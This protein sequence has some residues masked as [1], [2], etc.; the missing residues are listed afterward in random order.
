MGNPFEQIQGKKQEMRN[1]PDCNGSGKASNGD[2]CS[3]CGG[4][5]KIND[6]S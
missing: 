1:C 4:S 3:C 6:S 2:K 5:G